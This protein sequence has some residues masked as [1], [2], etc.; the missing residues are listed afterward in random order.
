MEFG[1]TQP[2][3][4]WSDGIPPI[5]LSASDTKKE[6]HQRYLQ[7]CDESHIE[8]LSWRYLVD[9]YTDQHS[10]RWCLPE[11][12]TLLKED[13]WRKDRGGNDVSCY[14]RFSRSHRSGKKGYH[15]RE[16]IQEALK[17][18][19]LRQGGEQKKAYITFL[20]LLST[21]SCPTMPDRCDTRLY[22]VS[23]SPICGPYDITSAELFNW[24]KSSH[25]YCIHIN[26]IFK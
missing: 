8:D 11:M 3:A 7:S 13:C 12:R 21:F 16:C 15:F 22:P 5:Y 1:I 2:E 26:F 10:S 9:P 4:P 20:M 19:E 6:V 25:R 23:S 24:R 18:M 17:K 14:K